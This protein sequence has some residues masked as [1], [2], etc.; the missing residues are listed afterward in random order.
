MQVKNADVSYE[1]FKMAP[2]KKKLFGKSNDA[3][4][5]HERVM[6]PASQWIYPL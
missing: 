3:Y 1:H 4:I 2:P 6:V 5:C